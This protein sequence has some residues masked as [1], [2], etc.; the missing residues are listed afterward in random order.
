MKFVLNISEAQTS[1]G[2]IPLRSPL[3]RE[4]VSQISKNC[5][6]LVSFP[7]LTEMFYFS[8]F[9]PRCFAAKSNIKPVGASRLLLN[10]GTIT[11]RD[12][13]PTDSVIPLSAELNK[14]Q[15]LKIPITILNCF[16]YFIFYF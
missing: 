8:G 6:T 7:P 9:A 2:L 1:L 3:L 11:R 4:W 10:C 5:E 13:V 14:Y 15:K 16:W 12:I